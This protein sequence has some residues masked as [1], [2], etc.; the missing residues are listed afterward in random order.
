MIAVQFKQDVYLDGDPT[1]GLEKIHDKGQGADRGDLRAF[2]E[3]ATPQ[4]PPDGQIII[5]GFPED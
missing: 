1:R 2:V 3:A 4:D 5:R